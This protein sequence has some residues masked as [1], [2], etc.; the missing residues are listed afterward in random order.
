MNNRM[1][2]C[3]MILTCFVQYTL[4]DGIWFERSAFRVPT[5]PQSGHLRIP[6]KAYPTDACRYPV[7][8]SLSFFSAI[9]T[10]AKRFTL[11]P[12]PLIYYTPETRLA[13]GAA[14]TATFRFRRDFARLKAAPFQP[15]DSIGPQS[16]PVRPSQIT[17]GVA[18]T[19]NRQLLFYVPFQ[20]FYDQDTYYANG[21]IGYYRYNYYF[22]GV[23]QRAVDPEL[24]GVNFP[25]V[26]LNV[27]RRIVPSL[28][29][30]KLYGGLRYQFED[31]RITTVEPGGRLANGTVG[32][33]LGSRLSGAGLGLFY[34][35]RDRVFFPS[36]G[37]VAD[38]TYLNQNRAL[39]GNV[40][41]DRYV[42]DVS[43]YHALGRHAIVALNYVVS[44]T[45]GTAPFNALSLLGGT[46]R[47]RG[48]YEGRYRDQNAALLQAE[49]RLNVYGRLGAVAFGAVGLLGDNVQWLR[50]QDPKAAYGAG[51]RFTLNR[52][53]HLNLRLDYG[54]GQQSSGFYLTVGEAF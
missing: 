17:L 26:R 4:D 35:A 46:K 54:I 12:L 30:G 39:G 52:R 29:P 41:F 53:D 15:V 47:L 13:Y 50:F 49:L 19:Q 37:L 45:T 18:Y 5:K 48:Y 32:G 8:S 44:I 21:E 38:L 2:V 1:G 31:Y 33:G 28:K 40:R 42:A 22:Y 9:D 43:S 3:F 36:A 7:V 6:K 25:R 10:T 16:T 14:A 51:L 11:I 27:F 24:Y 23:G 34:D 20:L